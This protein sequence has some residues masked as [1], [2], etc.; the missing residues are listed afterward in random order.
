MASSNGRG[1]PNERRL[2]RQDSF[3]GSVRERQ[4]DS[5]QRP[6]T[7]E[8]ESAEPSAPPRR[9]S[10]T[11]ASVCSASPTRGASLSARSAAWRSGGGG[12]G[13]REGGEKVDR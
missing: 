13:K 3:S 11:G 2:R 7:D 8:T 12:W 1:G 4:R 6:A 10:S 5:D 9:T